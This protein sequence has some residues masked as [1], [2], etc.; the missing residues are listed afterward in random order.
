M[1]LAEVIHVFKLLKDC[2][3]DA[4]SYL[5]VVFADVGVTVNTDV[6]QLI[7]SENI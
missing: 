6:F 5:L 2:I 7:F 3:F 1:T 4:S